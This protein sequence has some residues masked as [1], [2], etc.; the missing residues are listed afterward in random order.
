MK[1]IKNLIAIMIVALTLGMTFNA[2]AQ[3]TTQVVSGLKT[4]RLTT[5]Q[6]NSLA[7]PANPTTASAAAKGLVVFNTDTKHIEF[8]DGTRWVSIYDYSNMI[9][10]LSNYITSNFADSVLIHLNY[11]H[12]VDSIVMNI[13]ET[14]VDSIATHLTQTFRDSVFSHL[15]TSNTD[16]IWVHMNYENVI[17]TLTQYIT[18]NFVDSIATHITNNFMDSLSTHID[19]RF[20]DSV[21]SNVTIT[22]QYGINASI[23]GSHIH[24]AL[25]QG[26]SDHQILEWDSQ[27]NKWMP[28][29]TVNDNQIKELTITL[30]SNNTIG[31]ESLVFAGLTTASTKAIK[32]LNVQPVFTG[33]SEMKRTLLAVD[34]N[35]EVNSDGKIEWIVN[36]K[37]NNINS[38]KSCTLTK[39]TIA[40]ICVDDLTSDSS[41]INVYQQVGW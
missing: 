30:S 21:M 34:A 41:S 10:S 27:S 38:N 7:D 32:L 19:Q 14:F 20:T 3:T 8:W 2:E 33:D 25:P 22:G 16:S 11:E 39:I 29:N 5:A 13:T 17:D 28:S 31:T 12:L 15:T 6:R 35:G 9:D 1:K 37:N 18:N 4:P 36:I 24:V 23:D 26:T 40:Y